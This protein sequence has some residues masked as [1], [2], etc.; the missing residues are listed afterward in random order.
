MNR[1]PLILLPALALATA[2]ETAFAETAPESVVITAGAV[3]GAAIDPD[4]VP[5]NTQT[6]TGADLSRF[7][8]ASTLGTLA[9]DLAGV[10]LSDAQDNPFQPNLFYRGFEASPLA[11][12]AQ[13]LAVYANGVR[14]NQP[15]GDTLNW[16]V[17]PDIA[18][19]RLTLEGSNPVFGL[20]A[21]AGSLAIEF[22][23]GF[24]FSGA[25]AEGAAGSFGRY[26]GSFQFGAAE[27]HQALYIAGNY[28]DEAGWR[29]HSPSLL[30][31]IFADF[32]WQSESS[33]LH[34]DLV[35]ADN[36]L[37]GNGPAP[38]ELLAARRNAVFTYPDRTKNT[39]GLA[40]LHG[41]HRISEMLS[42]QGNAYI[43]HLRQRTLNGDAS[44]AEV[45][46]VTLCL[47]GD[48]LTGANGDPIPDFLS[49]G[50]YAQLNATNTG[51]TG[52]GGAIQASYLVPL[53]ARMNRILAG[54][55]FDGGDTN[56]SASSKIGALAPDRGFAGPGI[57]IVQ[58]DGSIAPV[59]LASDNRY[60]GIYAG[61]VIDVTE[62]FSV[63]LSA[64]YNIANIGIHDELGTALNG[65]HDYTHFNPAVG[66]TYKLDPEL[67]AYAGYAEANRAP[68]PAE[69]SCADPSAPCSLTNFFI[70]DPPLKQVVAHTIEAGLRG[71][72]ATAL[73]PRVTWHAG[74]FRAD[75]EDDI[76]FVASP[77][78]GR[79]YFQNIGDTRRQGA[80]T[81]L[82]VQSQSWTLSFDY[83]YTDAMFRSLLTLNSP[84][85]PLAD[86]NGQIQVSPGNR[87]PS[88]PEHLFK[89]TALAQ[90]LAGWSVALSVRAA[91]GVYLQ[92]DES[93]LNPKTDSYWV[94]DLGSEYQVSE[95]I[96][97]F[98]TLTNVF[99]ADY[100]T[101]GTF[102]P[103][104]DVPMAEA[105]GASDPRSL[106]PGRPRAIFGG[107]RV[108]M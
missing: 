60:Y 92:G 24:T 99:D 76:L 37:T 47:D 77:V 79:G 65:S 82:D 62:A 36:D 98:A 83:S 21:L 102:A 72:T 2:A 49:G 4:K 13:G 31:Q 50:T 44:E 93:N 95:R 81:S 107:V 33:E 85:N 23:N 90:P 11:G 18:I 78:I 58:A 10:S 52:Y 5:A 51:T 57:E 22:K 41:T 61:D 12:D 59:A 101:F 80:E 91:S 7:G 97:L 19:E 15:F 68:T 64:R 63:N 38:V 9:N 66:A 108:R 69:F 14:L 48:D 8:A 54:F 28:L 6:I 53:G 42:I 87:L 56:F 45:C 20:N 105:P 67:T 16:D 84:E 104:A 3:P 75:V 40:N 17:I 26:Q 1:I 106:S 89:A 71:S 96:S 86:S 100:E 74:L 70:S 29:D 25:E 32:G 94:V 43:S 88:L 35:G 39:Y 34:L 46:G 30:K 27:G 73:G 55:A 103:T